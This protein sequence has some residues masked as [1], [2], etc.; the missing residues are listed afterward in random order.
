MAAFQTQYSQDTARVL[1]FSALSILPTLIFFVAAE[2][3]IV[4]ALTGAVKG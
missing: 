3:R 4:G 2:K 1:A